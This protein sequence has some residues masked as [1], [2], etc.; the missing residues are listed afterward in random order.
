MDLTKTNPELTKYAGGPLADV[1]GRGR[2]RHD[3]SAEDGRAAAGPSA[4]PGRTAVPRSA[5]GPAATDPSSDPDAGGAGASRANRTRIPGV[6]GEHREPADRARAER[7][8]AADDRRPDPPADPRARDPP[9]A[10]HQNREALTMARNKPY[11][12]KLRLLRAVKS[13]RRVPAWV[14]QRTKRRFTRPPKKRSWRRNKLKAGGHGRA[15][16]RKHHDHPLAGPVGGVP[17]GP[18]AAG[19]QGDSGARAATPEAGSNLH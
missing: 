7:S 11:A 1:D 18:N 6:E 19:D 4:G 15:G 8:R 2:A 14:I 16:R 5:A 3:P 17:H 13:N 9:Q 10:G 12:K